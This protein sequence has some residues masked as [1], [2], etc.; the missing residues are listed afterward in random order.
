MT[1]DG[2]T[3]AA[4]EP[5]PLVPPD[6]VVQ[7]TAPAA[8]APVLETQAPQM[9]PQVDAAMLPELDA[10]VDGFLSS[11]EAS[12]AGSPE[13]TRQ[14]DSVRTMGDADIRRAAETSNRMLDKPVTALKQ[15]GIA[16]GSDVGKTLI[17]LRR[18]V[19][20]LDPSQARGAK[21]FWEMMPWND[22]VEDYF[23][24]YQSSQD[25]LN[26]ILHHL[27]SGQDE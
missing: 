24:K 17:A 10:K 1:S 7:L 11:L 16:E 15:G 14:A 9:A 8:P 13:F 25:Q 19:E 26:G 5:T 2:V 20:D 27:R 12:K 22:K 21:K 3:A 23:R 6:P 18:T 4:P